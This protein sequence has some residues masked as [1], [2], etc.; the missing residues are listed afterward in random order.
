MTNLL[1]G[2]AAPTLVRLLYAMVLLIA[3]GFVVAPGVRAAATPGFT[4]SYDLAS[5]STTSPT[6]VA[7]ARPSRESI[8]L[9][10]PG[11]AVAVYR[12]SNA[13]EEGATA[14]PDLGNL[15]PKIEG[16]L[17]KRGWTPQEIQE[18]YDN[19]EQVPAVNKANGE[20]AT[21]YINP[22]TGKSVVI[23]NGSGQVIHVGGEG[24]KYGPGSGD[25]P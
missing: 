21:R 8:V 4:H 5:T 23:E 3:S 16:D 9:A 24:F 10:S 6:N 7:S 15:S 2:K 17:L 18:A 11:A 1:H 19:G 12:S 14:A 25:L 13:T 20:A 22:T